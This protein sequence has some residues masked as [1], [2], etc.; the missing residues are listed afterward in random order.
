M[1]KKE[2]RYIECRHFEDSVHEKQRG[3]TGWQNQER[4]RKYGH[5]DTSFF[6]SSAHAF[7]ALCTRSITILSNTRTH[8]KQILSPG[9]LP[10]KAAD[11][12]LAIAPPYTTLILAH[13]STCPSDR[14]NLKKMGGLGSDIE[15]QLGSAFTKARLDKGQYL[16]GAV[17][18]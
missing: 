12:M 15:G 9:L 2:G 6:F 13:S 11:A 1:E 14:L 16:H 10:I 8:N 5:E 3:G 17:C 18:P 7:D 4:G